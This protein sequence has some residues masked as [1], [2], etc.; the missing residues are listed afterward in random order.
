[1]TEEEPPLRSTA[2]ESPW[3][4]RGLWWR[5]AWPSIILA[6]AAFQAGVLVTLAVV[7][8]RL[9]EPRSVAPAIAP[10][11]PEP[12]PTM[13]AATTL[14]P[15][16][17]PEP[18]P[19]SPPA[20]PDAPRPRPTQ[21]RTPPAAATPHAAPALVEIEIDSIPEGAT[22]RIAGA[23]W[24]VTPLTAFLPGDKPTAIE[25]ELVGHDI[26]RTRWNPGTGTRSV[27]VDL[28]PMENP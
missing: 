23:V 17:A 5:S 12:S 25:L 3:A 15:E 20:A 7:W 4:A 13:P 1:M 18:P 19:V 8:G 28:H 10:I 21:H 24:G 14:P 27:R 11:T 6:L 16:P 9:D 22:V 2:T 26:A